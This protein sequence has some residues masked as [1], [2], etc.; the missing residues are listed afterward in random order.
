M[1][2]F[3][4]NQIIRV[5]RQLGPALRLHRRQKGLRQTDL[6]AL[7]GLTQATISSVENGHRGIKFE[8]IESILAALDLEFTLR[9][10]TKGSYRDP[11]EF[12]KGVW[13]PV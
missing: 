3:Q 10:R 11:S 2:P 6:S 7:T 1:Y 5:S 8:T 9:P 12:E 13:P 4:D